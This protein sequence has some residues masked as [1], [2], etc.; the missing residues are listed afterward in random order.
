[1]GTMLLACSKEEI[2]RNK[3]E[4]RHKNEDI[5]RKDDAKKDLEYIRKTIEDVHPK[6]YGNMA[7]EEYEKKY[8]DIV[9]KVKKDISYEE[10]CMLAQELV[11]LTGD[12]NSY[13]KFNISNEELPVKFDISLKGMWAKNDYEKIKAGDM[14][15]YIGD[16]SIEE[17]AEEL[18]IFF[19]A[20]NEYSIIGKMPELMDDSRILKYLG[21]IDE[22]K[23]IKIETLSSNGE[24]VIS[25]V[26]L[27]EREELK[28]EPLKNTY[29]ISNKLAALRIVNLNID[30]KD[31]ETIGKFFSEVNKKS[32]SNI[33]IDFRSCSGNTEELTLEILKYLD[34]KE[35]KNYEIK[36]KESEIAKS[37]GI[38]RKEKKYKEKLKVKKAAD[39]ELYKG[40]IYIFNS[41]DTCKKAV[42]ISTVL[43]DN[44][45][46]KIV[47]T[48]TVYSPN[49]FGNE[50]EFQGEKSKVIFSV[51]TSE[52]LRPSESTEDTLI[53]DK[54]V[55]RGYTP[56][57][58]NDQY[59]VE[60]KNYMVK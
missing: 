46:A 52:L 10:I 36:I 20:E 25:Y 55:L 54:Y 15:R 22:K 17:I 56:S 39:I 5:I 14:I 19:P 37:Q 16:K 21:L 18:S 38:T 27:K 1:M 32:I 44:E 12:M 57:S 50:L 24:N 43:K 3:Y 51:S 4:V 8:N 13:V 45:L 31:R 47:G 9:N 28:E 48:Y 58:Q 49:K 29:D 7:K 23:G 41:Y 42:E 53:P 26:K 59:I 33:V 6:P 40:N 34:A 30:D 2:V 35:L 60:L 11:T